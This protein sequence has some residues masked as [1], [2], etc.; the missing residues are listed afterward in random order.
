MLL[1]SAS[2]PLCA[3]SCA[4]SQMISGGSLVAACGGR[5]ADERPRGDSYARWSRWMLVW[6]FCS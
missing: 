5:Y 2:G 6:L 4:T 3:S 1:S